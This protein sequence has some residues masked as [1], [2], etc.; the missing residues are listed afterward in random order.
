MNYIV[1]LFLLVAALLLLSAIPF[2]VP[3]LRMLA[4]SWVFA[5]VPL[6]ALLTLLQHR[7]LLKQ[8]QGSPSAFVRAFMG[9][10][11]L[12]MVLLVGGFVLALI[13]GVPEQAVFT[14]WFVLI[15]ISFTAYE[16]M[17]LS[18]ELKKQR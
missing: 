15:Y 17:L 5:L 6:F 4:H 9:M 2:F 8:N 13:L 1:R 10:T 3:S 7:Y 11:I 14:G 16:V 18:G 12:K